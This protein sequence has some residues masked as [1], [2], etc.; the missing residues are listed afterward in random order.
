MT[1]FSIRREKHGL[2]IHRFTFAPG[3]KSGC[4][5]DVIQGHGKFHTV[6]C[7]EECVNRECAKVGKRRGLR[8]QD[9]LCQIQV[10]SF[11][12]VEFKNIGKQNMLARAN[13]INVVHPDQTQQGGDCAGDAFAQDLA[14]AIPIQVGCG[15]GRKYAD[16]D[17]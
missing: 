5:K 15:Q 11:T 4:G 17:A 16:R 1:R 8:L 6:F 3:F 13:G 2:D 9:E 7:R 12:P 14:I 10:F